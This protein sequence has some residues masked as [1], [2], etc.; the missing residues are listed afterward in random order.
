MKNRGY[1]NK[2]SLFYLRVF[3]FIEEGGLGWFCNFII[4]KFLVYDIEK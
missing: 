2:V 3:I 1:F 4:C